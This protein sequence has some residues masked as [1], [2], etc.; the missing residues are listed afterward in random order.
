MNYYF[1][2]AIAGLLLF[3]SA[4]AL[5]VYYLYLLATVNGFSDDIFY[6]KTTTMLCVGGY[7]MF[8]IRS[9]L[10]SVLALRIQDKGLNA[11]ATVRK[12]EWSGQLEEERERCW[13]E[14]TLDIVPDDPRASRFTTETEQLFHRDGV[15]ML[16]A[17]NQLRVKY[18]PKS[19]QAVVIDPMAF[20][21]LK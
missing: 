20:V 9:Y 15:A 16:A 10:M 4:A 6:L 13:Y 5:M 8:L 11:T 17:G 14:L 2:V 3:V 7:A 1:S 21:R 18:D 19:L 12:V